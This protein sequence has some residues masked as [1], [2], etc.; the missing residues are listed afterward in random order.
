MKPFI[1]RFLP[2]FAGVV[3]LVVFLVSL[4]TKRDVIFSDGDSFWHIKAGSVMLKTHKLIDSDIFSHTAA[5]KSW[6]AHEWLS[7]VI[8][9]SIH[10]VAGL[11]GIFCFFLLITALT[12]WL[13]LKITEKQANQWVAFGCVAVALVFCQGHLSARPHL[14]TWLFMV[15]TLAILLK[16]GKQLFWMP[17][18]ITVWANLHGGFIL[19]IVLQLIFLFGTALE[20]RLVIKTPYREVLHQLKIPAFVLL[21]SIFAVGINPFGYELLLFP[22]Q[23]SKGVFSVMI[24]E[25]H[26]PDLQEMWYFRFYLIALVLL[27]S[28]S[29]SAVTWTERLLIVFFLN[30]ALTHIRHISLLLIALTP[31]VARMLNTYFDTYFRRSASNVGEQ[32]QL[33]ARS[34]PWLTVA[35]ALGLIVFGSIDHRSL[36]FLTPK[37]MIGVESEQLNQLVD[38]LDEN[39]PEGK[40]FNEYSLG[41]YLLYALATPPKVFIDGRADMY[42]EQILSDYD[43]I[44]S[45]RLEREGLLDKYEIDW[46]VFEQD[47]DLVKDLN[48]SNKWQT[49]YKN[50]HFAILTRIDLVNFLE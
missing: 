48:G 32:L 34:G 24:N 36:T 16:G 26:A 17:V 44:S 14:F 12:F 46:I 21:L 7:E 2:D 40:M 13:L 41:G 33:S 23:V 50:D 49:T 15:V 22:L 47:T 8:M 11:E 35:I 1:S 39:P 6:T 19:G 4:A 3:C 28:F 45:A 38:Y 31:F 27:V 18:I 20:N 30:A 25:W 37:K 42:G 5:G 9:A 43:K 29:K 10:K